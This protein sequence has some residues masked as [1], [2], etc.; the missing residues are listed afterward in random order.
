[1]LQLECCFFDLKMLF[2]F[3][4]VMRKTHPVLNKKKV[5]RKQA[6]LVLQTIIAISLVR[7]VTPPRREQYV[8][9]DDTRC[10]TVEGENEECG[11]HKH[12][13]YSV[14]GHFVNWQKTLLI[15]V[16]P[17]L[18]SNLASVSVVSFTTARSCIAGSSLVRGAT[19]TF[20]RL[21]R[22]VT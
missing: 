17:L 22:L 18:F 7:G 1:M 12:N 16:L 10:G 15:L 4:S 20:S 19:V 9:L 2:P 6:Y 14:K 8:T 13:A 11:I 3:L 5:S 21:P